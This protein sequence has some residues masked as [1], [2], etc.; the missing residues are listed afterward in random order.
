MKMKMTILKSILSI[1][2]SLG[3]DSGCLRA[4]LCCQARNPGLVSTLMS[5]AL[6]DTGTRISSGQDPAKAKSWWL[7]GKQLNK[8]RDFAPTL[9]RKLLHNP[10]P[11]VI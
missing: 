2:V 8:T 4:D 9:R 3:F 7:G 11:V 5:R 6:E 1:A 10:D